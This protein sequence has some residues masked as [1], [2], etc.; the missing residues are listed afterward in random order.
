[1]RLCCIDDTRGDPGIFELEE[2]TVPYSYTDDFG[3]E[4]A[5]RTRAPEVLR[6]NIIIDPQ[7]RDLLVRCM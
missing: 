1:M 3:I 2:N 7:L 4:R 5:I 6:E